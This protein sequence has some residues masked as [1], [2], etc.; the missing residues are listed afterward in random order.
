MCLSTKEITGQ[1]IDFLIIKGHLIKKINQLFAPHL[2]GQIP[3][4][5]RPELNRQPIL[6]TADCLI[7]KGVIL[8]SRR[9]Q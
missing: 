6:S 5:L 2:E 1:S 9:G 4:C 7:K 3:A 8:D